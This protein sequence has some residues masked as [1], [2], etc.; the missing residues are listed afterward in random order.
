LPRPPERDIFALTQQLK[1]RS[2]QEIPRAVNAEPVSFSVGHRRSFQL[3]NLDKKEPFTVQ[4]SLRLVS[5]SAYFYVEDGVSVS[6]GDLERAAAEM[7]GR[8]LPTIRRHFGR[9][10]QPGVDNDPRFYIVHAR[11]PLVAGYFNGVDGY[12]KVVNRFSNEIDAIYMN[13]QALRPGTQPYLSTLAHELQHMV[14]WN[15]DPTEEVWVNEGLS[16]LAAELAGFHPGLVQAFL[17]RPDTQLNAWDERPERTPP[18]YGAAFMFFRYLGFHYGGYE[19]LPELV[20]E[21]LNGIEGIDTYLVR[22]GAEKDFEGVFKDWA[23]ANYLNLDDGGPYSHPNQDFKVR[24]AQSIRDFREVDSTVSQFGADYYEVQV[25]PGSAVLEFQGS[26]LVKVLPTDPPSGENFY[27]SNRGDAIDSHMTREFDLTGLTRTT[28]TFSTWFG[29]EEGFDYGYVM[30]SRDG[31]R[32]WDILQGR[33]TTAENKLDNSFGH[34][35]TGKSGGG[36]QPRWI[37]ESVDLTPYAGGRV[38]VRFQYITDEAVN[39]EGWAIDDI[40]I[41]ELGFLDNAEGDGGWKMEG[42]V[43]TDNLLPQRFLVQVIER[44]S[45]VRVRDLPLDQQNAG[46]LAVCCF[47]Q[48]LEQVVVVVSGTT[49]V[50]TEAARYKLTVRP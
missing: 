19:R 45:Q 44:G 17:P 28:L 14:H 29:I 39:T 21:P 42:F 9:E 11:I 46:R 36:P 13:V 23:I 25:R 10:A 18:Y 2:D 38:L 47:G 33:S 35:Y 20:A 5:E 43:R 49:Q 22:I 24:G 41:P 40:A 37:E 12:P 4:A 1:L 15:Q 48:G 8:I 31:G 34:A 30:A 6:Q 7:E 50:T 27:W 3:I 32:T 16:E 26:P